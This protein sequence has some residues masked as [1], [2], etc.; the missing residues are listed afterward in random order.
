[1]NTSSPMEQNDN[2]AIWNGA[3]FLRSETLSPYD[4]P[5]QTLT[6]FTC[7]CGHELDHL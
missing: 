1:M 2:A 6:K 3:H 4:L 5:K 7:Q